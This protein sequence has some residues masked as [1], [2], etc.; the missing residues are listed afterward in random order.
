MEVVVDFGVCSIYA[1]ARLS[2]SYTNKT[3]NVN[4][5]LSFVMV[6]CTYF[7]LSPW[8]QKSIEFLFGLF[9]M[10][11]WVNLTDCCGFVGNL[12]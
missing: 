4:D 7:D 2:I 5:R 6:Q 9:G 10:G 3:S 11:F 12:T 1:H 8:L